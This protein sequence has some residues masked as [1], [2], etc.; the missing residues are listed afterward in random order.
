MQM[1]HHQQGLTILFAFSISHLT[2]VI[3]NE[4]NRCMGT[5]ENIL[6]EWML[7]NSQEFWPQIEGK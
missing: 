4:R 6:L 1:H 3:K 5:G 7:H 2:R